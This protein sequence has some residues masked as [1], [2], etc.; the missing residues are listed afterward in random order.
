MKTR[1]HGLPGILCAALVAGS[2]LLLISCGQE[3]GEEDQASMEPAAPPLEMA[4]GPGAPPEGAPPQGGPSRIDQVLAAI[5]DLSEEQTARVRDILQGSEDAVRH[6]QS[7]M[8]EWNA[9]SMAAINEVWDQEAERI[10]EVLNEAQQA[11]YDSWVADWLAERARD[12][13]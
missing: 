6:L 13:H 4:G 12:E 7:S 5:S 10:H 8:P 3:T 2:A 11:E 1:H 9:E